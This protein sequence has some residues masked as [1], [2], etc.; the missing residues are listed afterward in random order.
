MPA[1]SRGT[2]L[3]IEHASIHDGEGIQTVV[4]LKG[5][6]LRCAWC[7]T[8]EGMGPRPLTTAAG[9]TYGRVMDAD[10]LMREIEKDEVFFFHSGGGVT[11]SGGEALG[12]AEFVAELFPALPPP[13]HPD[14]PGK[15]PARLPRGH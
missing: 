10:Q 4:F 11:L 2:V 15:Q 3:R 8:P 6:P 5:C 9:R 14:H 7:S 1:T 12:Q 13:G